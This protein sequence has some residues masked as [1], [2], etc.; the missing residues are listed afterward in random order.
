[1]TSQCNVYWILHH[2][3]HAYL[4]IY[5]PQNILTLSQAERFIAIY[6]CQDLGSIPIY[7]QKFSP[8]PK[9]AKIPKPTTFIEISIGMEGFCFAEGV[10]SFHFRLEKRN[11]IIEGFL[12]FLDNCI[13]KRIFTHLDEISFIFS[14]LSVL[15]GDINE[16]GKLCEK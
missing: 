4:A 11:F 6:K 1:M 7:C 9:I 16:D 15:S 5:Y 10:N 14:V 13:R 12:Q 3:K 2:S 8:V